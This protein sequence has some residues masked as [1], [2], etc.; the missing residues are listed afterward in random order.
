MI[1][2]SVFFII[3]V[4]F[5]TVF[6]ISL[7]AYASDWYIYQTCDGS[8]CWLGSDFYH[9][10]PCERSDRSPAEI[11]EPYIG[12]IG[13]QKPPKLV[14]GEDGRVDVFTTGW[15]AGSS[16]EH[17]V[18]FGTAKQCQSFMDEQNR[19]EQKEREKLDKYR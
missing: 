17:Y 4:L 5:S 1:S 6:A 16:T 7:D 9:P 13:M 10:N 3:V 19:L 2:K 8:L 18:L 15:M 11:Y 14:E 12:I